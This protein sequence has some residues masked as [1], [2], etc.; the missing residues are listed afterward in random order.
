ML[1]STYRTAQELFFSHNPWIRRTSLALLVAAGALLI[2]LFIGIV[3]PLLALA[4]AVAVVGLALIL[5]DTHWG[6]VALAG[7]IFVLPFASL[8]FSIGFKPTFLDMAL[9]ALFFVWVFKLVTGHAKGVHRL[10]AGIAGGPLHADDALQLCQRPDP[11]RGQQLLHP[12]FY[13][14]AAGHQPL[15]RGHQHRAQQG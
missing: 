3:G 4:A 11:Q 2:A 1:D 14:A 15:L 7:V 10:A 8:P 13:G 12:P 9:G 6:F 5:D